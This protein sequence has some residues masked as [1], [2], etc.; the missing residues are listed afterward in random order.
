MAKSEIT[1]TGHGD[2][3]HGHVTV[4]YPEGTIQGWWTVYGGK[5]TGYSKVDPGDTGMSRHEAEAE[6]DAALEEYWQGV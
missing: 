5:G 2:A 1:V 4:E 6:L 3:E